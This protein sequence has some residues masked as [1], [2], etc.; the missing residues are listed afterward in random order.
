[1]LERGKER[2][3]KVLEEINNLKIKTI[4]HKVV[5]D[6]KQGHWCLGS[7]DAEQDTWWCDKAK[8]QQWMGSSSTIKAELPKLVDHKVQ[9]NSYQ[10]EPTLE[11]IRNWN[12]QKKL[13]IYINVFLHKR[14]VGTKNTLTCRW[15][16]L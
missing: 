13:T 9:W 6:Q 10:L 1:M 15:T 8:G 7:R 16:A 5:A 12:R 4:E 14:E 11:P 3:K 2:V